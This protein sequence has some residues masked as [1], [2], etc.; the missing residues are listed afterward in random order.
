MLP[1]TLDL[2]DGRVRFADDL[3]GARN[4]RGDL[5]PSPLDVSHFPFEAE[6]ARPPLEALVDEGGHHVQF[7]AGDP[8][9]LR[10][11]RFPAP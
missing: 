4:M 11:L 2:E 10:R 6:K 8:H 9:P 1:V 7:L 5:A 3:L